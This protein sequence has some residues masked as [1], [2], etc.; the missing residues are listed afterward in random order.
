LPHRR[1]RIGFQGTVNSKE[2]TTSNKVS[3]D[4]VFFSP[5]LTE[6]LLRSDFV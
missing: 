3:K 2:S 5:K 1:E 6:S 4:E